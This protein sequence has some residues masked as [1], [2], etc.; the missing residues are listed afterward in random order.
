MTRQGTWWSS[1]CEND[2]RGSGL[3]M[4]P[5]SAGYLPLHPPAGPS[6]IDC[7]K[8]RPNSLGGKRLKCNTGKGRN[9]HIDV[10]SI[11]FLGR[12][13]SLGGLLSLSSSCWF[14][15]LRKEMERSLDVSLSNTP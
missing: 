7:S 1:A 13:F 15:W 4:I 12:L 3:I 10:T 8:Y 5:R 14:S 11:L 6:L 2:G 9:R